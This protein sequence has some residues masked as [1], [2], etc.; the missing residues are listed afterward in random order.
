MAMTIRPVVAIRNG[1]NKI[2]AYEIALPGVIGP[3]FILG[4]YTNICGGLDAISD[5]EDHIRILR[6][7]SMYGHVFYEGLLG[8][9]YYGRIGKASEPYGDL[10]IFAFLDTPVE[11]CVERVKARREAAGNK[12]VFNEANTRGRIKKIER[13]KFR[14]LHEFHRKVVTIDHTDAVNQVFNLYRAIN[15][16]S[17]IK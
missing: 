8:S 1:A 5:V 14:L 10:H 11:V 4:P 13:L 2:E 16:S 15:G 17:H 3:L 7:A 12:K 6:H 9:E